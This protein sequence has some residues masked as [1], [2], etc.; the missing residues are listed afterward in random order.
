M[1]KNG[2]SPL[3]ETL[4]QA[5]AT[6][7]QF[8]RQQALLLH[9]PK[10]HVST[11]GRA[12]STAYEQLRNASE[13]I[14]A[15]L[16]FQR[17]TLRF[18]KRNLSFAFKKDPESLAQELIIELTQAEYIENDTV[19]AR[20]TD[21]L[22]H[23]IATYYQ[24]YW[25]LIDDHYGVPRD[26]AQ[27]WVLELLSVQSE[28]LFHNPLRILSF[29]HLAHAHF[30]KTM[31]IS[32]YI[33]PTES[34]ESGE[35]E[36]I[37]YISIH[38]ALLKSDDANVRNA[39]MRLYGIAAD[40]CTDF[41]TF[42]QNYDSLSLLKTTAKLARV[43]NKN[44]APLRIIRA[45]FFEC[46][47]AV[48]PRL[49]AQQSQTLTTIENH[50][51]EEYAQVRKR[52]NA[53]VVK[54][55]IFLLITKALIG[56]VVEIPYD[57]VVSGSIIII[58]L[59]INLL[60]PPVFIAISALTFKLPSSA[61]KIVLTQYVQSLIYTSGQPQLVRVIKAQRLNK[62]RTF[63]TIYV[64][65][66]VI[67]FLLVADRLY[68]LNFNIIQGLIFFVFLST[69]SFL[70][71]RLTVQ[72]KELE[73][74]TTSQGIFALLRDFL[75]APFIFVGQ[76]ISYRFAKM[77]IVAQVLDMVIELPLKTILRLTRQWTVFLSNKKDELL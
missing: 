62:S 13:N 21:E 45:T 47:E 53:G 63:N 25:Q 19:P 59:I 17:A 74:V 65:M 26:V 2:L 69:A 46:S 36:K 34:I 57:L 7:Q 31:T 22:D 32:D 5:V 28:Q 55:I 1:Q 18:Y 71:Y 42:N 56:V 14:E 23:L 10:I 4:Q 8:D 35:Y 68:A 20:M 6:I 75:Y 66:F 76:R 9:E 27:R 73:V 67:V 3:G 37:L 41:V 77:N 50:I 30:V 64:I 43:V 15:H 39:L 29:A 72:V 11:L 58:P 33:V 40:N 49:L 61:N 12:L 52:R 48:D 54:S 51:D 70:S 38:K 60:F 44:G 16:L 24:L